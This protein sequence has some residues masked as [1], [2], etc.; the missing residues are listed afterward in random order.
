MYYV[1]YVVHVVM[2]LVRTTPYEQNCFEMTKKY[3]PAAGV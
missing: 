2:C 3:A 1:V